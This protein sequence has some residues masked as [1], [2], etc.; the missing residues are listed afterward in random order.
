VTDVLHFFYVLGLVTLGAGL[1]VGGWAVW[2]LGRLSGFHPMSWQ[3]EQSLTVDQPAALTA[4]DRAARLL[5]V[6][7]DASPDVIRAAHRKL[8]QAAHPDLGGSTRRMEDL[9]WARELLLGVGV[10]R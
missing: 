4:R 5:Q 6:Q 8:A 10:R 1:V 7:P 9:N 2:Y 3:V